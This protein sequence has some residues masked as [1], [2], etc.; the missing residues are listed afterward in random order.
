MLIGLMEEISPKRGV[1]KIALMLV[2]AIIFFAP[3]TSGIGFPYSLVCMLAGAGLIL[4]G[5][6]S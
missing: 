5:H 3:F 1:K 2:G 6:M 4:D